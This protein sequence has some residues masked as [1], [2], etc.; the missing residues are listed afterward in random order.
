MI[1]NANRHPPNLIS[2]SPANRIAP[3]N[4][5]GDNELFAEPLLQILRVRNMGDQQFDSARMVAGHRGVLGIGYVLRIHGDK[6]LRSG[7]A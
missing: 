5:R 3:C 2:P 6:H 4:W 7:E 1:P